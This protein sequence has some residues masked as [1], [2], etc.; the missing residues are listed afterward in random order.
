MLADTA[1]SHVQ[2]VQVGNLAFY[3]DSD[4]PNIK[5]YSSTTELGTEFKR[6]VYHVD[7]I[8]WFTVS[9]LSL[10]PLTSRFVGP[11]LIMIRLHRPTAKNNLI[12]ITS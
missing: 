2:L 10:L 1:M 11:Y 8:M 5:P 6:L 9:L 7:C 4:T 12:F 3:W